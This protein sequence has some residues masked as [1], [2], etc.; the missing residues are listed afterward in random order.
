[1]A[2]VGSLACVMLGPGS[3]DGAPTSIKAL[4]KVFRGLDAYNSGAEP[5]SV[6]EALASSRCHGGQ[7]FALD[8]ARLRGAL[9]ERARAHGHRRDAW[10]SGVA[11]G[12]RAVI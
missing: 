4:S 6:S 10:G 8:V 3:T 9:P 12:F 5:P 11:F 7:Q 1:M 2:Q